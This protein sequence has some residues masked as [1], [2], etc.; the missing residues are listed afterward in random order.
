MEKMSHKEL[1]QVVIQSLIRKQVELKSP[2]TVIHFLHSRP[3]KAIANVGQKCELS[4]RIIF[5][6]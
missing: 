2:I 6:R 3:W 1:K 4:R 5:K